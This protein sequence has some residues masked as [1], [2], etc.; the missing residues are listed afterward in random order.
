VWQRVL[1][2]RSLLLTPQQQIDAWLRFAALCREQGQAHSSLS[3]L[4]RLLGADS[5]AFML[6]PDLPLPEAQPEMALALLEHQYHRGH[7][8]VAYQRL[9]E[10]VRSEQLRVPA[11]RAPRE[12]RAPAAEKKEPA[13]VRAEAGPDADADTNA[14]P[15]ASALPAALSAA[16]DAAKLAE[17]KA[18]CFVALAQWRLT[19]LEEDPAALG[20]AY[21]D[22]LAGSQDAHDAASEAPSRTSG[23]GSLA[24]SVTLTALPDPQRAPGSSGRSPP[25]SPGSSPP[26]SPPLSPASS[27]SGRGSSDRGAQRHWTRFVTGHLGDPGAASGVSQVLYFLRQ[28]TRY[29]PTNASAWHEWSML[30]FRLA[31]QPYNPAHYAR[32]APATN[33]CAACLAAPSACS[34]DDDGRAEPADEDDDLPHELD[35]QQQHEAAPA[36]APRGAPLNLRGSIIMTHAHARSLSLSDAHPGSFSPDAVHTC[37]APVVSPDDYVVPAIRGFFQSIALAVRA[38]AWTPTCIQ[39]LLRVLAMW[40]AHGQQPHVAAEVAR[41][42][43]AIPIET[44]LDVLPQLLARLH[45]PHDGIRAGLIELVCSIALAHPQALLYSLT[46]ARKAS[47]HRRRQAAEQVLNRVRLHAPALVAEAHMVSSE[48]VRVSMLWTETWH[49]ALEEAA[50]QYFALKNPAEMVRVLAPLHAELERGGGTVKELQFQQ[51]YGRDLAEA[52]EAL[53]KFV[54]ASRLRVVGV[55]VPPPANVSAATLVP[56]Q[57]ERYCSLAWET[58]SAVFR[59]LAKQLVGAELDLAQASPALLHARALQVAIPGTYVIGQPVLRIESFRP[60]LRVIDSKQHPRALVLCGSDGQQYQFLLKGHEDLRQDERVMQLFGLVNALLATTPSAAAQQGAA[61]AEAGGDAHLHTPV[62]QTPRGQGGSALELWGRAHPLYALCRAQV[63]A[64]VAA[65]GEPAEDDWSAPLC[66]SLSTVPEHALSIVRYSVTPLSPNSGLIEWVPDTDTMFALIKQSR[67]ARLVVINTEQRLMLKFAPDLALLTVPQRVEA[68]EHCLARTRGDDLAQV[69]WLKAPSAQVWLERRHNFTRSLAVMSMVGYVLGLGDRH[70]CNLMLARGSGKLV[71]I[72][73]GDCFEVAMHRD[74]FPE[75]VPFRLTRALLEAMEVSRVEGTFRLTCERTMA[76]MRANR[77]SVMAVLEAFVYDP[78][79]AWR[80]FDADDADP[81]DEA[82]A[83]P[84][85]L[86]GDE[87]APGDEE[88]ARPSPAEPAAYRSLGGLAPEPAPA[89]SGDP[90]AMRAPGSARGSVYRVPLALGSQALQ[91]LH[92]GGGLGL[93]EPE[94]GDE[95]PDA[96]TI[97]AT[98]A[99]DEPDAEPEGLRNTKAVTIVNRVEAKLRGSDFPRVGSWRTDPAACVCAREDG[100]CSCPVPDKAVVAEALTVAEQVQRLIQ[101]A[102]S[103]DKLCQ[104]YIGW[105]YYW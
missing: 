36:P 30:N 18:R 88:P 87:P 70:P 66:V 5:E 97:H 16:C 33:P 39:D 1:S 81:A 9:L 78:L 103:H 31:S 105:C 67:D 84:M 65:D 85:A 102:T 90:L 28:A 80:L 98:A 13:S 42:V 71:H 73:F 22:S 26:A 29:C 101:D 93:P 46:V 45:T 55:A 68:F 94:D 2:V 38:H 60:V 51:A 7:R 59:K 12:D 86:P 10:L 35:A 17:L 100:V 99:P 8:R 95:V 92:G 63:Q 62:P 34:D 19:A 27:S 40:M 41:G 14:D 83:A 58:Y 77:N 11:P 48:L 54:W 37:A 72:D 104:C 57:A 76:A 79:M 64:Q 89:V 50:R 75:K 32:N 15:C 47:S 61:E 4:H 56:S 20:A 6:A 52:Y 49:E 3:V 24:G 69:A 21:A 53:K 82:S 43:Q 96:A 23:S 25:H 44:W 91:A 74:K